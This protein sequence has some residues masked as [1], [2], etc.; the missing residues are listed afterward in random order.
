[1]RGLTHLCVTQHRSCSALGEK[2]TAAHY[3]NDLTE[4]KTWTGDIK[5]WT[6]MYVKWLFPFEPGD[7]PGQFKV[8]WWRGGLTLSTRSK[9]SV[10]SRCRGRWTSLVRFQQV[11]TWRREG[12]MEGRKEGGLPADLGAAFWGG[13]S[14][15][16]GP[17]PIPCSRGVDLAFTLGFGRLRFGLRGASIPDQ[18]TQEL[19]LG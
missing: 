15:A 6:V 18:F 5:K 7:L 4:L 19:E 2:R 10:G 16:C 12:R 17:G 11:M 8:S 14:L 13:D 1:M 9:C 3:I